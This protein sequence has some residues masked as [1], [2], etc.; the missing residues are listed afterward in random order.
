MTPCSNGWKIFGRWFSKVWNG[1]RCSHRRGSTVGPAE[2]VNLRSQ[3][4]EANE[5]VGW[6]VH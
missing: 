3:V 5:D 4:T 1:A 6:K 2:N